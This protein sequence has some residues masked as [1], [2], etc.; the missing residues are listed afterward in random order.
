MIVL[1]L[2]TI[3]IVLFL[4]KYE[5][6][7]V[8]FVKEFKH[9]HGPKDFPLVGNLFCIDK[10][11]LG[12]F[13]EFSKIFWHGSTSKF[14]IFDQVFITITDPAIIQ[15]VFTSPQFHKRPSMLKFFEMESGLFTSNCK[16][17][18]KKSSV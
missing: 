14:V 11:K 2:V 7:R 6:N 8:N 13:E 1:V 17:S 16:I 12:D 9:I 10:Q 15:Q 5:L 4:L 18:L 3:V